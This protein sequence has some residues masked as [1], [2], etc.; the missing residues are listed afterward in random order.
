MDHIKQNTSGLYL[1]LQKI[2]CFFRS[3]CLLAEYKTGKKLTISQLNKLWVKSLAFEYM[4]VDFL[5]KNSAKIATIALQELGDKGKIV[6]V[7]TFR[8]GKMNWYANVEHRADFY[9]QKIMQ[10]G[11]NKTHFIVVDKYGE[12]IED[13]HDPVIKKQG[14]FYTICYQYIEAK[15]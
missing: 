3:A 4:T 12:L 14:V 11:P 15:E 9:I 2:G 7:A 6:E 5:V 13:P 1:P 8:D 10:N